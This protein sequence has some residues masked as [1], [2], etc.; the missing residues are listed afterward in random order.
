MLQLQCWLLQCSSQE[1]TDWLHHDS[2]T[3]ATIM[4]ELKE[5]ISFLTP[6]MW[7][8]RQTDGG[9]ARACPDP[10]DTQLPTH[11]RKETNWQITN[12]T[13]HIV[14][15]IAEEVQER[16]FEQNSRKMQQN[17]VGLTGHDTHRAICDSE[18][19]Q[20]RPWLTDSRPHSVWIRVNAAAEDAS[21]PMMMTHARLETI[22]ASWAADNAR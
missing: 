2:Q 17:M 20:K 5:N 1:T 14:G 15:G 9:V 19:K 11:P 10:Q 21:D 7:T 4:N 8:D 13:W 18:N 12:N 16:M 22:M 3:D 6:A